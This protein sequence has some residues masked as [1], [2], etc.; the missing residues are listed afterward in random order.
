[1][2][3]LRTR[4]Q[5][6]L[7]PNLARWFKDA[8]A[9]RAIAQ[10]E[11]TTRLGRTGAAELKDKVDQLAAQS[12]ALIAR[13]F[14]DEAWNS[15]ATLSRR[16]AF[17]RLEAELTALLQQAGY[18]PVTDYPIWTAVPTSVRKAFAEFDARSRRVEEL[19]RIVTGLRRKISELQA[20]AIWHGN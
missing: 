12:R 14:G 2:L 10:H 1:M 13:E 7:V 19:N 15:P 4:V 20:A 5:S 16:A 8:A 3:A 9:A 17:Q 6:E 11:V 18:K